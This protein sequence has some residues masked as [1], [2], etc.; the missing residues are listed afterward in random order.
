MTREATSMNAP[1]II[2][3][4]SCVLVVFAALSISRIVRARAAGR[5]DRRAVQPDRILFR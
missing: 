5:A 4:A 3:V 1:W 2:V